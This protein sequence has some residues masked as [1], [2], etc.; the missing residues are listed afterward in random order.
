VKLFGKGGRFNGRKDYAKLPAADRVITFYAEDGSSWPHLEPIVTALVEQ[1][2][3]SICYLT[4]S[5]DDPI[6]TADRAGVRPFSVGE[7]MGRSFLFQTME[8]G[9]LVATVPQLGIA[10]LPRSRH[11]EH[12]GTQYLYVF[13]SMASTHMIYEPDGFD[14]YDTIFTVGP[15]MEPEL[16]RREALAGLPVRELI[17]HGYGRLDT[18]RRQ[19]ADVARPAGVGP[20]TVLVAPSWGPTCIF[21][22]IGVPIVQALLDGGCR[23]IARP[24]PMTAKRTPRAIDE[25]TS[26]FGSHP[27]VVI[28]RDVAAT[29]SLAESHLMVSDW[30]GAALEYAFG[31]ERPVL[32]VDVERKV[33]N[34]EYESF[35]I[36]PFE[37]GIRELIG[38]VVAPDDLTALAPAVHALV[39]DAPAWPARLAAIRE[40]SIF[41][42]GRSGEV[43]AAV[44]AEK[45]ATFRTKQRIA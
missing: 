13:H 29:T 10:V 16:R 44:V 30:S 8:T 24:H 14:H 22:T 18:I 33:N 39:A 36:E 7:G 20:P 28:D 4:S 42:V 11:A 5:D 37:V 43:A 31:F 32:F 34:P 2:G 3:E 40:E 35:G 12:L 27:D 9:V 6:L 17:P 25:L 15:Y 41:N 23:V 1:H 38:G 26:V 19:V 21:E 45:A